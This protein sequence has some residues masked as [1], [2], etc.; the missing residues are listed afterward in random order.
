MKYLKTYE[1]FSS[2][3]REQILSDLNDIFDE[4]RDDNLNVDISRAKDPKVWKDSISVGI[5][6]NP[7][8]ESVVDF[9]TIVF[10]IF[11]ICFS[12]SAL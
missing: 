2:E 3:D 4:L 10:Y 9:S 12:T 5:H 1:N 8:G 11:F 6:T 7:T